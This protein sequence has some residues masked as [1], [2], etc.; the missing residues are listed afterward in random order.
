[1]ESTPPTTQHAQQPFRLLDKRSVAGGAHFVQRYFTR[2]L[3]SVLAELGVP[4]STAAT[5]FY[6]LLAFSNA[7]KHFGQRV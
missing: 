2:L 6:A 1:M 7:F 4:P 5:V 3:A